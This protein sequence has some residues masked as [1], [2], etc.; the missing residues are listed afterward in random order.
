[1]RF[2]VAENESENEI[3]VSFLIFSKIG[4]EKWKVLEKLD[5]KMVLGIFE[6]F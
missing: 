6:L 3:A 2:F 5:T 1:V 4:L